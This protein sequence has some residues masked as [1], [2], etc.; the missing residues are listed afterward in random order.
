MCFLFVCQ[1]EEAAGAERAPDEEEGE[2][3]EEGGGRGGKVEGGEEGDGGGG[4]GRFP[5]DTMS[6]PV[7]CVCRKPDINCFMM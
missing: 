7:Y 4:R 3:G 6:A 2:E 1:S 5:M